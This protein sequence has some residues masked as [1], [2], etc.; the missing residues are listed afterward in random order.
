MSNELFDALVELERE[1]GIK[2]SDVLSAIKNAIAVAVRKYYN[3]GEENVEVE[4]DT[5]LKKFKV[6][7]IKEVVI[8]LTDPTTQIHID[9]A[10]IKNKRARIGQMLN[11]KLDTK[12]IGRIAALSGKNLIHQGINDAVKAQLMDQYQSKLHE[13]VNAKVQKVEPRTGNATILIDKNEAILFKNEQIPNE[14]LV[15]GDNI[16]VYV[17][18]VVSSERR[19]SIKVTRT[20]KDLVKRLFEME[21]P[22]IFDGTVEIKSIS[23]EPGSR[24]KIAVWS[25]D[26][27]VDP[28]GSCI[29]QKF[30]R[31]SKIVN[32]LN[33]EKI[34][35]VKYYEDPAKFIAQALSPSDVISVEIL[36]PDEKICRV[37]VPDTQLSLAIGNKGQNAKLAAKLTG[38]KIDIRPESGIMDTDKE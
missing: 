29:G 6:A 27:N 31:V 37:I 38:Y 14:I 9:E 32:E 20:H 21:V 13:V 19:C 12:Q 18:D 24:T 4:L 35:I 33:G 22:E 10:L 2:S 7:L 8:E 16:K 5:D 30:S 34:D 17:N 36:S 11:M 23:R 15:E 26:E 1:K 28:V 3:V 25:K